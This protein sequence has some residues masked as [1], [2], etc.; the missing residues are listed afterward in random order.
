MPAMNYDSSS[1]EAG[2]IGICELATY[3]GRKS[4]TAW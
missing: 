4:L 2:A 3:V 1:A